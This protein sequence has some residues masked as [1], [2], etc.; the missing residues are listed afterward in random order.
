MEGAG[1]H[2]ISYCRRLRNERAVIGGKAYSMAQHGFARHREFTPVITR[3]EM[4]VF[5]LKADEATKRQYPFDFD[6][7]VP[8]AWRIPG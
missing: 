3:N 6:L 8:I 7:R 1:A 2:F 4:A 5:S